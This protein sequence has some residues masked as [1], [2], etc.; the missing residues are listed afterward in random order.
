LSTL[1]RKQILAACA[2]DRLQ[3]HALK[4]R[5]DKSGKVGGIRVVRKITF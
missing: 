3:S 2:V 1:D 4:K 5:S